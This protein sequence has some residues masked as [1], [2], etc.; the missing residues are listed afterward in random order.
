MRYLPL[1]LTS[2]CLLTFSVDLRAQSQ[3]EM[4]LTSAADLDKAD[5][6]LNSLFKLILTKNADQKEFCA[7]L[8]EAQRA[9]IKFVEFHM[10]TLYPLKE[11]ENPR[12]VYGSSY[13]TEFAASKTILIKQRIKQ[14]A[15]LEGDAS[16]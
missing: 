15:E 4:N 1:L 10:K 11:G 13:P 16:K 7:D 2:L 5:A 14:L 12:Q 8:K 3:A 9:W 6:K